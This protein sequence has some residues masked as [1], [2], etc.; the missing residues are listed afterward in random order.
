MKKNMQAEFKESNIMLTC[1]KTI[2]AFTLFTPKSAQDFLFIIYV[3]WLSII[4]VY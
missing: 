3:Y 2:Y 4:Y 1:W